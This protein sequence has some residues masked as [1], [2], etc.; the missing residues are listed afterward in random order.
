MATRNPT[1]GLTSVDA[2]R[3]QKIL[4]RNLEE[5]VKILQELAPRALPSIDPVA[6]QT[7]ASNREVVGQITAALNRLSA[8][9]YGVCARCGG[10]IDPD[11]LEVIP[12][13]TTCM[14]CPPHASAA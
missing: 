7:A 2:D 13:A 4:E 3:F 6:Y 11:R 1:T 10:Q 8:G 14:E 5:R 9:T 12:Y